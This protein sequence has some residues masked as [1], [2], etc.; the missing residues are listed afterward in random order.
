MGNK[1]KT[2]VKND[3]RKA[4]YQNKSFQWNANK[5]VSKCSLLGRLAQLTII[6]IFFKSLI[7]YSI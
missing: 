6:S 4:I 1:Q 5:Y 3:P 2:S 7:K